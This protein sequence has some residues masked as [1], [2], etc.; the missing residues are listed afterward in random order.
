MEK[1]RF[2]FKS[3]LEC[4]GNVLPLKKDLSLMQIMKNKKKSVCIF[5]NYSLRTTCFDRISCLI[6]V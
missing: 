4:E 3:S 2:L 6:Q 1:I 5:Q